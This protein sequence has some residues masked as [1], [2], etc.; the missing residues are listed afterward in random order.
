[1]TP[2]QRRNVEQQLAD[3]EALTSKPT[4]FP[5]QQTPRQIRD[6]ANGPWEACRHWRGMHIVEHHDDWS[7]ED[8][9][10]CFDCGDDVP[11]AS[12]IDDSN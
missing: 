7:T 10:L 1:M 9:W 8:R 2:R 6:A 5:R 3:S 4:G 11:L 12:M